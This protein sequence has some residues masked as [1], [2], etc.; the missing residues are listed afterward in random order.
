MVADDDAGRAAAIAVLRAGGV[1]ALP[2]DT[3][4]GIAVALET[5]GGIERLFAVK[6][7]PPEKGIAL[8]LAEAE[9]AYRFGERTAA[10]AALATAF[11]PG[12]L[13]L[14][15]R[16]RTDVA[17]PEVLRGGAP[18]VGVRLPD[19]ATPRAL[20][21]E[22]GPLPT[23]SANLSGAPD[24]LDAAE[25]VAQL[26]DAL[27]LVLDGGRTRGAVPST[28]VDVTGDEARILRHGAIEDDRIELALRG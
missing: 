17:L 6:R 28:V 16:A 5:P 10:A 20:A 26:G 12:P 22:L 9:Q 4:Y 14:V 1:V 7:R 3:V 8:L 18:T 13:T 21:A 24:A 19:H 11:W 2:T 25:V 15:L 23:T 27:D